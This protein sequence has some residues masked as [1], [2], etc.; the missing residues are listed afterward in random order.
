MQTLHFMQH[1]SSHRS[2]RPL[3]DPVRSSVSHMYN[4]CR[5]SEWDQ[6]GKT[7]TGMHKERKT[8]DQAPGVPVV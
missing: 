3:A 1:S 6:V 2:L 7:S 5:L 4:F 8:R